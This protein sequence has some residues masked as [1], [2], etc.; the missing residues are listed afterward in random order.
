MK[1]SVRGELEAA[2]IVFHLLLDSLSEQDLAR[3]SQNPAWTNRQIIFHIVLG[4][5]LLPSLS[6][7]GLV[8]GRLS[9]SYSQIF[10]RLLNSLTKPFNVINAAGAY[11]G[12][13]ICSRAALSKLFDKVY[14][15]SL[16]IADHIPSQDWTRG[17]YY[18]TKWDPLFASYMTVEDIFRFPVR[19][20][21]SHIRQITR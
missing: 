6:L 10:A 13:L 2:R 18:P 16:L 14:A 20:F 1:A 9:P 21:Y 3:P 19:H 4:F 8:F 7:I 12:G 15:L 17:M 11:G 5:C